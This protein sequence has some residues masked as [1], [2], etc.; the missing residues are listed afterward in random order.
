MLL[1]WLF[2]NPISPH[3]VKRPGRLPTLFVAGHTAPVR[4][5]VSIHALLKPSVVNFIVGLACRS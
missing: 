5:R 4:L 2:T 1:A 3:Q